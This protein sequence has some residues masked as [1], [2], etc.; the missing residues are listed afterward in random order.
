MKGRIIGLNPTV[1]L[2]R[3][4]RHGSWA[5]RRRGRYSIQPGRSATT[6]MTVRPSQAV[7]GHL[8][9]LRSCPL[10]HLSQHQTASRQRLRSG[11]PVEARRGSSAAPVWYERCFGGIRRR[12]LRRGSTPTSGTRRTAVRRHC[13]NWSLRNRVPMRCQG[14][15]PNSF[16]PLTLTPDRKRSLQT[17]S[18][19]FSVRTC[20]R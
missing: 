3:G 2:T 14:Q 16:R 11:L 10:R 12:Q 8:A 13:V 1:S 6:P 18:N 19:L 5:E 7:L 15:E 9:V 20:G 4:Y 17:V